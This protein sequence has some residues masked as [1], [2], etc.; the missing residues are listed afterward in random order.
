[1][2]RGA[3]LLVEFSTGWRIGRGDLIF[4]ERLFLRYKWS[5]EPSRKGTRHDG[6]EDNSDDH[7]PSLL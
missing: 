2:A 1:M 7:Q 4:R 6:S 5:D 3:M